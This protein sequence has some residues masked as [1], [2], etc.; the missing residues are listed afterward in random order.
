[1]LLR[2]ALNS[3]VQCQVGSSGHPVRLDD[4]RE[5]LRQSLIQW[6]NAASSGGGVRHGDAQMK[7]VPATLAVLLAGSLSAMAHDIPAEVAEI[8]ARRCIQGRQQPC[9]ATRFPSRNGPA[10]RRPGHPSGRS[11]P[12][13]RS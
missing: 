11:V 2:E 7:I 9:Q 1:M 4:F 5:P 3:V 10:L 12:C 8:A 13:L 6:F